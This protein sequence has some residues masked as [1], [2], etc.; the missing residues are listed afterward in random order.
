MGGLTKFTVVAILAAFAGVYAAE[1]LRSGGYEIFERQLGQWQTWPAAGTPSAD[2]YTRGHFI[3]SG[4]L[5]LS[6]FEA[7][8]L[9]ARH[10]AAGQPLSS[11]CTYRIAGTLP[12]VRRWS[13]SSYNV[14]EAQNTH[15]SSNSTLNS[16]QVQSKPD[17]Q[18]EL[19]L[20]V[21]PVT[22]NWLHPNGEGNQTLLLR[23]FNPTYSAGR[24]T[25]A[26]APL[27]IE[28]LSCL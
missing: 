11:D 15:A 10:D 23:L 27:A 18:V 26:T 14:D 1:A 16:L 25:I 4:R 5:P 6:R 17:G 8:E 2:P 9:E 21:F 12:P 20:S 22:G 3:A 13:L 19:T 28:R 7:L 24:D